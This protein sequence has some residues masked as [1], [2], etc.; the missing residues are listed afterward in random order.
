MSKRI[1]NVIGYRVR[2]T[3]TT[4]G[5]DGE[6]KQ[7]HRQAGR[8]YQIKAAAYELRDLVARQYPDAVVEVLEVQKRDRAEIV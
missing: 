5:E 3:T 7:Y 4:T 8:R 1:G 6:Q 2:V